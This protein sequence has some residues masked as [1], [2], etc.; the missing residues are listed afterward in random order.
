MLVGIV[1]G[2]VVGLRVGTIVVGDGIEVGIMV[3][4]TRLPDPEAVKDRV[5]LSVAKTVN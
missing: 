4:V 5:L 3:G 1:V 2:M